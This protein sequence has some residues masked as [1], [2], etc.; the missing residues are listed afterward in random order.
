MSNTTTVNHIGISRPM[1]V[2]ILKLDLT[3]TFG[4]RGDTCVG[5]GDVSERRYEW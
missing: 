4:S 1:A 5:W 2:N 3:A